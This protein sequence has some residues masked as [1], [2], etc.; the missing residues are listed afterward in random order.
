MALKVK[1]QRK[2]EVGRLFGVCARGVGHGYATFPG[3][4]VADVVDAG[5]MASDEL[6]VGKLADDVIAKIVVAHNNGIRLIGLLDDLGLG[7]N[8]P[9]RV[10]PHITPSVNQALERF[11]CKDTERGGARHNPERPS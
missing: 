7:E 4:A 11:L 2:G 8:A 1:Q 5:A 10:D 6:E 3:L 9:G